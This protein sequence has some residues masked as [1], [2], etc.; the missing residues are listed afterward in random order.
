MT[1]V[2]LQE[3]V[4]HFE[5]LAHAKGGRTVWLDIS[6]IPLPVVRTNGSGGAAT[7]GNGE[8]QPGGRV[9]RANGTSNG[10]LLMHV[11][12]DVTTIR[13]LFELLR[14]RF[15]P[16][17]SVDGAAEGADALTRREPEVLR[18]VAQGT[19]TKTIAEKL[20]VSGAT[21]RNHVQ[22][23][24]GKLGTHSRLE[25]VACAHRNRLL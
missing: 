24:L 16:P 21:V 22:N 25:A 23:I 8:A 4:Q 10:F 13:E 15:A 14:E 17:R 2:R 19:N 18:L 20:H 11:F 6:V 5:M 9:H 7:A 12:R 3:P 1:V